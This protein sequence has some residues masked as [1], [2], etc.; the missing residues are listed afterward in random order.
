[1]IKFIIRRILIMIPQLFILSILIFCLAKAMP[2]DALTGAAFNPHMSQQALQ[3]MKQKLGL[4]DPMPVQYGRWIEGI[5]H[6]NL[7]TSYA[8]QR[9]VTDIINERLSNT[10]TLSICIL[11]VTYLIAIPL[12]IVSGRWP[13]SW[14]D[15]LITGYNYVTFATPLFIFALLV[16][17]LFGFVLQWFPTGGS[18][19]I[20]LTQGSFAYYVNKIDHLVLPTISG[21]IIQTVGTVQ[22]L[23]SEII[24]T[25]YKDFIK[26]ARAKGVPESKIYTRHILRN[27]I[28]PI[29]AFLGYD[30]TLVIGGNIILEGIYSFP[31]LGQLFLQSVTSRDF[32][33]VNALVMLTGLASL[34]GTLLSDIILSA[35]DPRIRIE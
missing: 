33:V 18:V 23:K 8:N 10:L 5:F 27:S 20:Q 17:F 12:G 35:V 9:P 31:G 30:I 7:G 11:I 6:G 14:S 28:L 29:A 26:T 21:A 1:M 15:K 3:E 25:K 4:N 24:D 19:D 32:S 34:F 16:L 22:Y 13:N 2:G